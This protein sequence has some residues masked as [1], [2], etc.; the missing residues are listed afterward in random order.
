MEKEEKP[1][2]MLGDGY[3]GWGAVLKDEPDS[4]LGDGYNDED[5]V[6]VTS[7]DTT[8]NGHAGTDVYDGSI[9]GK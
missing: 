9:I 8:G 2:G 1:N 6:F 3:D 7:G 5:A 4:K